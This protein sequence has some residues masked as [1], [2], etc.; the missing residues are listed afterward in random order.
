MKNILLIDLDDT[1][2]D[3]SKSEYVAVKETLTRFGLPA[4]DEVATLYKNINIE[5]WKDF[6]KGLIERSD[7]AHLRFDRLLQKIDVK[8]VTGQQVNDVYCT[9]LAKQHFVMDGAIDFLKKISKTYRVIGVSNGTSKVQ[10]QRIKE[11]GIDKLC[12][13]IYVSEDIGCRKPNVDFFDYVES[14]TNGFVKE[15]ALIVGDSLSSDI[16][17]GKN[18]GITTVWFNLHNITSSLPDYVVRSF[19]ELYDLLKRLSK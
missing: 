11:S 7:L 16:A 9:L 12:E 1:V 15:N 17:G 5:V 10:W 18:Y 4:S 6:E 2:L 19:T 14:H 13:S 8:T 3:F